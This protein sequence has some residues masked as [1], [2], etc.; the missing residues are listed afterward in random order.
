[1]KVTKDKVE[2]NQVF[3][4]VEMEPADMEEL[5][6]RRLEAE[7]RSLPELDDIWSDS[8]QGV[9]IIHAETRDEFDDLDLIWQ[10]VRNRMKDVLE[11]GGVPVGHMV[12]EFATRG[13]AKILEPTGVDF[14]IVDMEHTGHSAERIADLMAWFKAVTVTP[15]VR[16]PQPLYH[17]IKLLL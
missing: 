9:T 13:I 16:V 17:F 1:M 15:F 4:T 8:K 11:K 10:K 5:V 7:L 3:L 2:S 6:T 14:V 12:S